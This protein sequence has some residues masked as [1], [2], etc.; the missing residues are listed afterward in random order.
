MNIYVAC[1][2][3]WVDIDDDV[4]KPIFE[5]QEWGYR[6]CCVCGEGIECTVINYKE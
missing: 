3:E 6:P 5:D 2:P 4:C 1:I